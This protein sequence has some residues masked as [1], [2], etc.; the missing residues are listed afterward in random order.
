MKKI[1]IYVGFLALFSISCT[2]LAQNTQKLVSD[3]LVKEYSKQQLTLMLNAIGQITLAQNVEH[4]VKAYKITYKTHDI[5]NQE[6]TASGLIVVPSNNNCSWSL[7]TYLHGTVTKKDDV[8]SNLS[9]EAQLGSFG[10]AIVGAV[11][12]LPDYLGLG[13]SPGLHPYVHAKTEASASLDM[14]RATREFCQKQNIYLNDD[15][16]L[17]G[18]SQGGHA[19]LA[20]QKHIEKNYADEFNI[21]YSIPMAGP[22]DLSG[23]QK[24]LVLQDNEFTNPFYLPYVILSYRSLYPKLTEYSLDSIFV[25]PYDTVANY[26]NGQYVPDQINAY[27][28][29]KPKDML[30]ANFY[31]DLMDN[32]NHPL[33]LALEENDLTDW[34]PTAPV[35]FYYC[36]GDKT[37]SPQNS[38]IA[39]QKM[40]A[41]EG[42]NIEITN[43][44]DLF[45]HNTCVIPSLASALNNF[46]RLATEC[47]LSMEK[48]ELLS[49][50][51]F[52]NP[53]S[54]EFKF[55]SDVQNKVTIHSL[56]GQVLIQRSIQPGMNT[57][58]VSQL[59]LGVYL[60]KS[61]SNTQKLVI[62]R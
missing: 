1:K 51:I 2:T 16:F 57:I 46:K 25:S 35:H 32:P 28:P 14:L 18:Y 41:M 52:P 30:T 19:T 12:A 24:D 13:D 8:P 33:E 29:K 59:K 15:L 21:K 55:M 54:N 60:V 26:F 36:G 17:F 5:N 43:I 50:Q 4:G 7:M 42:T 9:L 45:N 39:H 34:T 48:Q 44:G 61:G 27:L 22:Y 10:A 37:V 53:T 11:V 38:I 31:S 40:S 49:R 3:T 23:V 58:D 47:N 6:S 56:N 62:N 20:L